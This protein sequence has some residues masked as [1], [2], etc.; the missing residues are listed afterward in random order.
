LERL[1]IACSKP[2]LADEYLVAKLT[3]IGVVVVVKHVEHGFGLP[4][5]PP[6]EGRDGGLLGVLGFQD[7]LD[8]T[9]LDVELGHGFPF[10]MILA[11][12]RRR[13]D[14]NQDDEDEN[15]SADQNLGHGTAP[16]FRIL[17]G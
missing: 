10:S 7:D 17:D 4:L 16:C 14:C 2:S 15:G 13:A 1:G 12:G 9:G 3:I 8:L 6:L 5:A 11:C